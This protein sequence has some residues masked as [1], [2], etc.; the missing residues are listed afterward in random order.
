MFYKKILKYFL[1]F[2]IVAGFIYAQLWLLGYKRNTE[3]VFGVSF[4]PDYTRYLQ[5]DGK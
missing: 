4:T 2:L 3:M 1:I 5:I